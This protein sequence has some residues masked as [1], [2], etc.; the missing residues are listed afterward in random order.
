MLVAS[1]AG[2]NQDFLCI[3]QGWLIQ[4]KRTTYKH[5]PLLNCKGRQLFK[6][7]SETHAE[8][9]PHHLPVFNKRN[10]LMPSEAEVLFLYTLQ[11]LG[12]DWSGMSAQSGADALD[13][14]GSDVATLVAPG[15]ANVS[16]NGGQIGIR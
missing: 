3:I 7:L 9:L 4:F 14:I 12:I 1:Q 6:H 8:K 13:V 16:E 5:L 11:I 2:F 10:G 15:S